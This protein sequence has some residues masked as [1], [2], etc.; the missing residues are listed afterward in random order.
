MMD[1][2]K[3]PITGYQEETHHRQGVL[4]DAILRQNALLT[5]LCDASIFCQSGTAAPK[6]TALG[7]LPE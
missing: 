7:L 2:I 3:K 4:N 5:P 6:R 1:L